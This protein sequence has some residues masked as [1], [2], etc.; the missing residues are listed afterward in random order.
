MLLMPRPHVMGHNNP[1]TSEVFA[2]E[3]TK[4]SVEE[5]AM[6]V[7]VGNL[8][9]LSLGFYCDSY[10]HLSEKKINQETKTKFAACNYDNRI[11]RQNNLAIGRFTSAMDQMMTHNHQ[12][13][14]SESTLQSLH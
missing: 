6:D 1:G 12:D 4:D 2:S 3:L 13:I 7:P 14:N 5:L 8:N 11:Q 9:E 10:Y